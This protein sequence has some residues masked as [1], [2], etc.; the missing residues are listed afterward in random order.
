MLEPSAPPMPLDEHQY[1]NPYPYA[2]DNTATPVVVGTVVPT[3]VEATPAT[4]YYPGDPL[5]SQPALPTSTPSTM[6]PLHIGSGEDIHGDPIDSD[7]TNYHETP[8][9]SNWL[10]GIRI[11][12]IL[13]AIIWLI[14]GI[15]SAVLNSYSGYSPAASGSF[16]GFLGF[17]VS[18]YYYFT[19]GLR[20]SG[21]VT[22]SIIN[23]VSA[24]IAMGCLASSF[25]EL[26][27]LQACLS[28]D[29]TTGTFYGNND[30]Y[31]D[32]IE[33]ANQDNF[34][35]ND[36]NCVNSNNNDCI[37]YDGGVGKCDAMLQYSPNLANDSFSL[38][39]I[40]VVFTILISLCFCYTVTEKDVDDSR[41]V[42][43]Y[44]TLPSSATSTTENPYGSGYYT[45]TPTLPPPP[46]PTYGF[47]GYG[48]SGYGG[49]GYGG[50]GGYRNTNI[51]IIDVGG[52]TN[53]PMHGS[54]S[55]RSHHHHH[56]GGG[57]SGP[58]LPRLFSPI[59]GGGAHHHHHSGGGGGFGGHHH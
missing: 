27:L 45:P 51:N 50:Y 19:R 3:E 52:T 54:Y 4:A 42:W 8:K 14:L 25:T 57:G 13:L 29:S 55:S 53:S 43:W 7:T 35:W 56:H 5:I 6:N 32:L 18:L 20:Y 59:S 22:L 37:V 15:Y 46:T 10:M 11:A 44:R 12:H 38:S 34:A 17:A 16:F 24:V 30:Y 33:C 26:G 47:G 36:C 21:Y 41:A 58:P 2:V 40:Q 49:Y 39:I 23:V 9:P 48:Y 31:P 28:G 1:H